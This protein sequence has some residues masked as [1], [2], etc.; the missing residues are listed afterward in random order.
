MGQVPN[1]VWYNKYSSFASGASKSLIVRF[2]RRFATCQRCS[3]RRQSSGT[4]EIATIRARTSSLRFVSCIEIWLEPKEQHVPQIIED[5]FVHGWVSAFGC[6]NRTLDDLT[7]FLARR[8]TRREIGSINRKAGDG[9][10]YG[11]RECLEREISIRAVSLGKPVEHV[12]QNI[13]VVPHREFHYLEFFRIQQMTKRNRVTNETMERLSDRPLGRRIDQQLRHLIRKIVAR[14]AIHAPVFAQ[15]LRA[16]EN[17]FC[18]HVNGAPI[19]GQR[20]PK[21]LRATLLKFFEILSGQVKT[22]GVIDSQAC[23]CASAH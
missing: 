16:G 3:E 20:D 18:D 12:A 22:I 4:S 5:R 21:R 11:T 19:F 17:F 7:I 10:A 14:R 15:R 8:L 2:Q 1:R 9:L 6:A 23:Y 13:D